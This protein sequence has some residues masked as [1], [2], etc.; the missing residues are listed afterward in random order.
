MDVVGEVVIGNKIYS[1]RYGQPPRPV[2]VGRD[3]SQTPPVGLA[4]N[5]PRRPSRSKGA[6][7]TTDLDEW[8]PRPRHTEPDY[9]NVR[10]NGAKMFSNS[11]EENIYEEISELHKRM[12]AMDVM[13][14]VT[15]V[16]IGHNAVL[17]QLNLD[18]E[19]FLEP[20]AP[21]TPRLPADSHADEA[22]QRSSST[23]SPPLTLHNDKEPGS[24][25][26]RSKARHPKTLSAR[27]KSAASFTTTPTPDQSRG[28]IQRNSSFASTSSTSSASSHR[29]HA[30]NGLSGWTEKCSHFLA[31]RSRTS[32]G[33]GQ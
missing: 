6:F 20:P 23:A 24:E 22:R 1:A 26:G 21:P 30:L 3:A 17:S 11:R 33:R 29:H 5:E 31:R 8:P 28:A 27:S 18:L 12:D 4:F 19:E 32:I 10:Q 13:D 2:Q 16:H 25:G 15:R 9:I 7:V 14:E